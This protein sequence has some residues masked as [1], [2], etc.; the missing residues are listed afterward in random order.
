VH[1]YPIIADYRSGHP[2]IL[3]PQIHDLV[4][5]E[6]GIGAGTSIRFKMRA[7]GQTQTFRAL[8]AEPEPGR[9]LVETNVEGT[10]SS[11]TFTVDPGEGGRDSI[12]TIATQFTVR[13]GLAGVLEERLVSRYLRRIYDEELARLDACARPASSF[14]TAQASYRKAPA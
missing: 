10:P 5:A 12:V 4:V 13:R 2:R 3:P 9:V 11:T 7:F 8:V 1:V 14:A 6:G